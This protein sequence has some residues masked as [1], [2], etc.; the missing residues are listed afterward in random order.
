MEVPVRT[1]DHH[2]IVVQIVFFWVGYF[3]KRENILSIY[4]YQLS[5]E[6]RKFY[7]FL[8]KYDFWTVVG[9]PTTQ[10]TDAR[11]RTCLESDVFFRSIWGS[12]D[13]CGQT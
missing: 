3:D 8:K 6:V 12:D 1:N 7:F 9:I 4:I 5:Q 2:S 13:F 11:I 10:E